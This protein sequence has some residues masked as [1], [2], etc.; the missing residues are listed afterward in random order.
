ML[1]V[2]RD[3]RIVN[4]DKRDGTLTAT[5]TDTITGNVITKAFGFVS[6]DILQNAENYAREQ[7]ILV[8]GV[9][10]STKNIELRAQEKL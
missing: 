2:L 7:V 4:V 6:E 1:E 5:G 10:P 8:I 3:A 9:N